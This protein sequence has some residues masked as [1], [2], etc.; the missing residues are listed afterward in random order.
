MHILII[1]N[2]LLV[3][4][5]YVKTHQIVHYSRGSLV[6]I[7]ITLFKRLKNKVCSLMI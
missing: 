7:N 5:V 1:L 2:V 6:H 4:L 3:L